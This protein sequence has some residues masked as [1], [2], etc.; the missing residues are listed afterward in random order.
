MWAIFIG[1]TPLQAI[2]ISFITACGEFGYD[3]PWLTKIWG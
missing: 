2:K 1:S 3:D